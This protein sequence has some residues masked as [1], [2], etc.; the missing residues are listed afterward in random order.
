MR[1]LAT[2]SN[3]ITETSKQEEKCYIRYICKT[4][5]VNNNFIFYEWN[6]PEILDIVHDHMK[7]N[8]SKQVEDV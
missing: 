3:T 2:L 7:G 4:T 6:S 5:N 8:G 1:M